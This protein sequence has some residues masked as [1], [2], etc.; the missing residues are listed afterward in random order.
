[1]DLVT[2]AVPEKR[3]ATT[4]AENLH[5]CFRSLGNRIKYEQIYNWLSENTKMGNSTA[6]DWKNIVRTTI[7]RKKTEFTKDP[8]GFWTDLTLQLPARN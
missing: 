3:D 8:R 2:G 6:A 1:V 7:A 5:D 4:V